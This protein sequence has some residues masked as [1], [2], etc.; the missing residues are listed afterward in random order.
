MVLGEM[1]A[2]WF[3]DTLNCDHSS[4]QTLSKLS[5]TVSKRIMELV[6]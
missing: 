1:R 5:V 6:N 3:W 4:S 2:A